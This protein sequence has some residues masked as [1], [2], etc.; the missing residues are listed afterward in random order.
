MG[1]ELV[2]EDTS[3]D[4]EQDERTRR[5][6]KDSE[7]EVDTED[8]GCD[9]DCELDKS[10]AVHGVGTRF[11]ALRLDGVDEEENREE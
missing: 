4:S 1:D 3:E 8:E 9:D 7:D 2:G 5:D 6:F 11:G 10:V